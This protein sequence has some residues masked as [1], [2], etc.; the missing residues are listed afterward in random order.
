MIISTYNSHF[1]CFFQAEYWIK[2]KGYP[3]SENTWEPIENLNCHRLIRKFEKDLKRK[4]G[5]AK[6]YYEFER[7]IAKRCINGNVSDNG[8]LFRRF[9]VHLSYVTC[10]ACLLL[11]R[12]RLLI[13]LCLFV[14]VCSFVHEIQ[15]EYLVKWVGAPD[16]SSTWI[17]SKDLLHQD[18][19]KQLY[20]N[21]ILSHFSPVSQPVSHI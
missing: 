21:S 19:T 20:N 1:G 7:I 17:S 11:F 14:Y 10:V 13:V 18:I 4:E 15:D 8:L 16:S 6:E 9:V 12:D 5:T 3:D 2:Y